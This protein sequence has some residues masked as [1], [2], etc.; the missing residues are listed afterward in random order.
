MSWTII[1]SPPDIAPSSPSPQPQASSERSLTAPQ[2]RTLAHYVTWTFSHADRSTGLDFVLPAAESTATDSKRRD[3]RIEG[4]R[5]NEGSP[6]SA[7]PG[8]ANR[9]GSVGPQGGYMDAGRAKAIQQWVVKTSP[10]R[11]EESEESDDDGEDAED[12]ED[13][14]SGSELN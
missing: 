2:L 6:A 10:E 12:V 8:G 9:V 13:E 7:R 5:Q 1:R 14:S 11:Q 3:S 4:S